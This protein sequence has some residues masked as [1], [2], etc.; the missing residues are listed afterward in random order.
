MPGLAR[1]VIAETAVDGVAMTPGDRVMLLWGAAN[2][3]PDVFAAA[4]HFRLDRGAN[5]HI[6]FGAG[7]HRCV[8]APLARLEMRVALEEVLR[9][10]P[11][12]RLTDP[13]AV[14]VRWTVGR[15]FSHLDVTW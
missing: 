15:E 8:G 11:Q 1:T 9:R 12:V 2:R 7:V 5:K 6:A 3:D 13:D 10:M 4:E 14:G